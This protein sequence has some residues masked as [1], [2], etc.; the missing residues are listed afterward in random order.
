[1]SK[2]QMVYIEDVC[3]ILDNFRIPITSSERTKGIYPYYGANGVQDYV[4]SYIFDDEL[5]L[6]AEDGGNFGSKKRPIAYRVSGKCW[7]NNHAHV[8]KPKNGLNVEYLCYSLMF[9]NV[10]NLINGATRQKLNQSALKKMQIPLPPLEE[11]KKIAEELDNI[12]DLIAKRKSQQTKLDLLVKAKFVEMFGDP[13]NNPMGWEKA[14]LSKRC[15]IVTGNTPSRLNIQNYGSYIEWIK[16]DNINTPNT[17]LSKATEYLSEYGFKKCR[18]VNKDSILM[19]CIAGSIS[20]I[21]NIAITDRRVAFNQQINAI[22]PNKNNKFYI[23]WLMYLTKRYIQSTIN[24][25]L[26]GILS[27]GQLSRL[28]FIFPPLLLQNKFA[29][30]VTKVEKQKEIIQKALLKLE[31]LYNARMQEYFE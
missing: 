26:K 24:M 13:I 6:V 12:T 14:E 28:E 15:E 7:I 23:Y 3:E 2:W 5:V 25:S 11:Q 19:T 16:S 29:D 21:G 17:Y 4:D 8:L 18:Y 1:M 9:Y 27:K 22:V 10:A 30:Y 20:C 31:I